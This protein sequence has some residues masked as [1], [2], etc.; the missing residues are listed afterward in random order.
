MRRVFSLLL[1]G[2]LVL[3]AC[4]STTAPFTGVAVNAAPPSAAAFPDTSAPGCAD[5]PG[6][7]SGAIVFGADNNLY[8]V[9]VDG[10]ATIQL[11]TVTANT[12]AYEPSW[13]PDGQTLAYTLSAPTDDPDLSW[14]PVGRICALDRSTG[15]GRLLARGS[16][17]L[18]S[19]TEA[20]WTPD[21]AALI[22]TA[23]QPQLDGNKVYTGDRM[24][25][26]R[27]D[28][29]NGTQQPL[30]TNGFNP[31]LAPDGQRL[32]YIQLNSDDLST[33]LWFA[34]ADG[35]SAQPM[36]MP[37]TTLGLISGPRWSPDGRQI[38]F[39]ATGSTTGLATPRRSWLERLLGV[40]VARAHG[41]PVDIWIVDAEG[42][43]T[44]QLTHKGLDDP[45][46]AWSPDGKQVAYTNGFGGVFVLDLATD[47][48]RKLTDAGNYGGISWAR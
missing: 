27:Y 6:P 32:T 18:E 24:T 14:L 3:S 20:T 38:V 42:R 23:H 47:Q 2:A 13:S 15:K 36:P 5:A 21:G 46:L 28:L 25:I 12:Y 43:A 33:Q 37:Q 10:G 41:L 31:T 30:I 16:T 45:R 4:G 9:G 35:Q 48:A 44:R 7:I 34:N 17:P 22:L 19:L 11:T 40:Q 29:A 8:A 39:G 26:T 1:L